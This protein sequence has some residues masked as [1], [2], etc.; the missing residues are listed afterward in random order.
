[1]PLASFLVLRGRCRYCG[2]E[3]YWF[4]LC[5]ELAALTVAVAA[6][7]ADGIDNGGVWQVWI[8]AMLGWALLTAAWIDAKTF[9]LPDLITL[10]LVLAGLAVTCVDQQT[11]PYDHA[12]AAAIGLCQLPPARPGLSGAQAPSW[13]GQG[14][15]KLMAPGP[16]WGYGRFALRRHDRAG[17]IGI[18]MTILAGQPNGPRRQ[19]RITFGPS[20]ALAFFVWQLLVRM[21]VV[22]F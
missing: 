3:I 7:C 2:A 10:P 16:D 17:L 22:Q 8:D 13:V 9:R 1:M 18:G 21:T 14:D 4:H 12:A 6:P 20:L 15:A 5:I 11:P 19:Q